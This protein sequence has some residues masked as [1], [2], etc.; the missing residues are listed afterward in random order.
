VITR[1]RIRS[2]RTPGKKAVD[3]ARRRRCK[4]LDACG[5]AGPRGIAAPR[6]DRVQNMASAS[7]K[8]MDSSRF[9]R[10]EGGEHVSTE[11]GILHHTPG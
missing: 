2:K 11:S 4:H 10:T 7:E 8:C 5:R 3:Q 1:G 9:A 6:G